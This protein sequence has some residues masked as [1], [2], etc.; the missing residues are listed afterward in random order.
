MRDPGRSWRERLS[1][2][3]RD[4]ERIRRIYS[5]NLILIIVS[6]AAALL[7]F[8]VTKFFGPGARE[9]I[10]NPEETR[11]V[12]ELTRAIEGVDFDVRIN[13]ERSGDTS[14][15]VNAIPDKAA[16]SD[17]QIERLFARTGAIVY[18]QSRLD[19]A[20]VTITIFERLGSGNREELAV[21]AV[22]QTTLAEISRSE[23]AR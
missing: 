13:K 20:H 12:A 22:R 18:D 14:I 10:R 16:R 2:E 19:S 23:E 4:N 1:Q 7:V 3:Q 5:R 9:Q 17:R 21:V 11:L 6:L 8:L 15:A